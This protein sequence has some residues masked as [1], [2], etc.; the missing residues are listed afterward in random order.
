M[1]ER[2]S[3]KFDFN[4]KITLFVV[5]FFPILLKLGFLAA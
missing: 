3:L 4:W 5:V 1:T 2:Q